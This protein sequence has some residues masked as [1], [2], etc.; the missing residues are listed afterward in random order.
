PGARQQQQS[1]GA[2]WRQV[3]GS[4]LPRGSL[5][6]PWVAGEPVPDI[7]ARRAAEPFQFRRL[8]GQQAQNPVHIRPHRRRPA[9][10][11]GPHAGTDIVDDRNG[12][13]GCADLARDA[14]REVGAVYCDKT[15]GLL[16]YDGIGGLADTPHQ[17]RQVAQYRA[18]AHKGNLAR[19]EDRGEAKG[20]KMAAADAAQ[21]DLAAGKR[22]KRLDH[23]RAQQVARFF[24]RDDCE[25]Q[26]AIRQGALVHVSSL[27]GIPITNMPRALARAIIGGPSRTS[28]WPASTPIPARPAAWASST[29]RNPIAGRSART[30]CP[31]LA[32][33]TR[34]PRVLPASRP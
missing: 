11:P 7:D 30:S 1:L 12:R 28:V 34:T 22:P 3:P 16:P 10:P 33:L 4:S 18:Q 6:H 25:L 27:G 8:E 14:E 5:Q 31:G 2:T 24:P 13:I 17:P 9:R 15:V 19:I 26:R 21:P 32:H 23:V 29:V 20:A